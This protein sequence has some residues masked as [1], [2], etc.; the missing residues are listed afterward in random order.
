MRFDFSFLLSRVRARSRDIFARYR[1]DGGDQS[2]K[3]DRVCSERKANGR[4]EK[5]IFPPDLGQVRSWSNRSELIERTHRHASG[6]A[7]KTS[8][9]ERAAMLR[10]KLF[11][12]HTWQ[13]YEIPSYNLRVFAFNLEQ[14]F[15]KQC[16]TLRRQPRAFFKC[17]AKFLRKFISPKFDLFFF[18]I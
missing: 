18:L 15:L 11:S 3:S 9:S 8:T 7:S 14:Y 13:L 17:F 16:S 1:V 10:L 5:E 12:L 4:H 6:I 2:G